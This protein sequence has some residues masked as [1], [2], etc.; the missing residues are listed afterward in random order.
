LESSVVGADPDQVWLARDRNL[1]GAED[2]CNL[3][4]ELGRTARL[5]GQLVAVGGVGYDVGAAQAGQPG[6]PAGAGYL[7]ARPE[8]KREAETAA[9]QG[10]E[11]AQ[12]GAGDP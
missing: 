8:I 2:R 5:E 7:G 12:A 3:Q 1:A 4:A 9:G 11:V 6:Q 10:A